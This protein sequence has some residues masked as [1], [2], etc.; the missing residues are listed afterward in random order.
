M[1]ITNAIGKYLQTGRSWYNRDPATIK[2]ITCHHDAIPHD[3]KSAHQ[4]MELIKTIH[5]NNGWPGA[6]YHYLIHRDGTVYQMNEHKW[7]TW[8]DGHN[9]DSIGIVLTGWFH[10]P[11][12]NK[13][14]PQQKESLFQLLDKLKTDLRLTN[15]DIL[16]HR[17]RLASACPGDLAFPLLAEYKNRPTQPTAEELLRSQN[18]ILQAEIEKLSKDLT[19]TRDT[20]TEALIDQQ[21]ISADYQGLAKGCEVARTALQE[22]YTEL[23]AKHQAEIKQAK[24]LGVQLEAAEEMAENL[25]RLIGF[26]DN[27]FEKTKLFISFSD[28]IELPAKAEKLV[29]R[30][31]T[32]EAARQKTLSDFTIGERFRSIW[33]ELWAG[34]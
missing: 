14:T 23:H 33:R 31:E 5:S 12:N 13:P 21:R 20:L 29:E 26:Y 1:K 4:I 25:Q 10:A 28:V 34:E 30:V 15:A 6:S 22:R 7:V 19:N 27:V 11:H 3:G 9:W 24:E 18:A 8:H 17:Q 16:G 2:K 32:A